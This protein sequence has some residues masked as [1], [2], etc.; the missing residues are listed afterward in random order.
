MEI[1]S[2]GY[3]YEGSELE[4][5]DNAKNWKKYFSK[6]LKPYIKGHVLEVG[7]GIGSNTKML[8]AGGA[9]SW[10]CLEPDSEQVSILKERL[11]T[12]EN[13]FETKF[14]CGTTDNLSDSYDTIIYIDVLEHIKEDKLELTKASKHLAPQGKIIVLSPAYQ[15]LFSEFDQSIGHYRR[16]NKSSIRK[17]TPSNLRLEKSYY[18]DSVGLATSLV[19]KIFLRQ[20]LPTIPQIKFWDTT[21]VPVSKIIDPL[22]FKLAGRS[23]IA[24]WSKNE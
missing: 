12:N 23:I 14:I 10:T 20:S 1:K 11:A 18:L 15:F 16:Y 2:N 4:L 17:A 5:F 19:N 8:S 21:I 6:T 24:I 7:A 9:T 3:V 22:I 13:S